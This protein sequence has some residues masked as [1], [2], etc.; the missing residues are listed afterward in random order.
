MHTEA[1]RSA[2]VERRVHK[3]ICFRCV[4][5]N[6]YTRLVRAGERARAHR[7]AKQTQ[8]GVK[9]TSSSSSSSCTQIQNDLCR[10]NAAIAIKISGLAQVTVRAALLTRPTLVQRSFYYFFTIAFMAHLFTRRARASALVAAGARVR[11][12]LLFNK[13]VILRIKCIRFVWWPR[14][15]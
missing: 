10:V 3:T 7:N 2:A 14:T 9:H 15:Q 6:T 8:H 1:R 13:S 12:V 5:P 4:L 11:G